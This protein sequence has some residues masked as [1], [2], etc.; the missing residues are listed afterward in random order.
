MI[1]LYDDQVKAED[2]LRAAMRLFR[3]VLLYAPCGW[4]K[5]VVLSHLIWLARQKNKRIIFAVHRKELIQQTAN[6]FDEFGLSY[7]FIAPGRPLN[8]CAHLF[9]ASI[10]TLVN[11]LGQFPADLLVIDEA[12]RSMAATWERTVQHYRAEGSYILGCSA[13]PVRMDGRGLRSNFEVMVKGPPPSYLM[14][15][16]RLAKYRLFVPHQPDTSGLRVVRGD[17]RTDEVDALMNKPAV[18]GDAHSEW[19]KHAQAL[20]TVAFCNSIEHSQAVAAEFR[21]RGVPALHIDGET[22][23]TIRSGALREL[24]DGKIQVV[25]N[26]GLFTDGVD[27]AALARKP[28]RIEAVLNLRLTKSIPLWEQ[29]CGR[30]SRPGPPSIM[31]DMAGVSLVLGMPDDDKEWSLDGV[32]KQ[33]K[34][35]PTS[36]RVCPKCWAANKSGVRECVECKQA[37]PVESRKFE[38]REGTLAEVTAEER[39]ARAEKRREGFERS[40]ANSL[41]SLRAFAKKKGYNDRWA[42]HIWAARQKKK[43]ASQAKPAQDAE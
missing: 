15:N 26:V 7:S 8:R 11:R 30:M 28:C 9:I 5:T 32:E 1:T 39:A 36:V 17:Y 29:I 2:D 38:K 14:A 33:S 18:T 12:H 34:K 4:G 41:E 10:P 27:I 20:R 16:G 22:D 31:L 40:Q 24:A 6:T 19:I 23:D 3:S 13:S 42:E 43:L 37:F 25:T 35:K 21:G